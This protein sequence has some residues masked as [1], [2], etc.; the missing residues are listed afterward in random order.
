MS[1]YNQIM[2]E[3]VRFSSKGSRPQGKTGVRTNDPQRTMANILEV[4]MVEFGEKGHQQAHDLL[5]LR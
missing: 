5:L 2:N 4:A 3:L 1:V